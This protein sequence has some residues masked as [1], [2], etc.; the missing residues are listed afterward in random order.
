M[1]LWREIRTGDKPPDL[2]N[3]IVEVISGSRDKYEYR[4][5][6][7]AFVLGRDLHSSVVFPV[8]YGFIPRAGSSITTP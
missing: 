3:V 1:N 4:A 5:D 8:D 2:I 6:W 7:E